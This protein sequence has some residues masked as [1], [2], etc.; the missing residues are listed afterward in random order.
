MRDAQIRSEVG[1]LVVVSYC[2]L[3]SQTVVSAQIRLDVG[4]GAVVSYSVSAWHTV[5]SPHS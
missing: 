4:V 1:V 3:P 2:K 5:I